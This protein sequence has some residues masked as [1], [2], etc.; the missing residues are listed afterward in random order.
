M[1]LEQLPH[2]SEIMDQPMKEMS[3]VGNNEISK[4]IIS[5]MHDCVHIVCLN[6]N[7]ASKMYFIW[8][9]YISSCQHTSKWLCCNEE[10]Y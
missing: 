3:C 7:T 8:N 1:K 9:S 10:C 2:E 6:Y 4:P 5:S